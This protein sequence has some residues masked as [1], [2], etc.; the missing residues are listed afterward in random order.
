MTPIKD[1]KGKKLKTLAAS[2]ERKPRWK[3][4]RMMGASKVTVPGCSA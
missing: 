4:G 3:K 2:K 1:G